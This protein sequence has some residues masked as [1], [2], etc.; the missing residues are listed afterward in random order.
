MKS[1]D[2]IPQLKEAKRGDLILYREDNKI[3]NI[4]SLYFPAGVPI[5]DIM[6]YPYKIDSIQKDENKITSVGVT[7]THFT[8]FRSPIETFNAFNGSIAKMR[9]VGY[10]EDI[11]MVLPIAEVRLFDDINT[12]LTEKF[13]LQL[14]KMRQEM[15]PFRP[16]L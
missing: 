2:E 13:K 10:L 7:E 6:A 8:S 9:K 1:W 5:F 12:F 4:R 14:P 16:Q 3:P 15:E 11:K